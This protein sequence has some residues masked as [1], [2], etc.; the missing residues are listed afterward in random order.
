MSAEQLA[1][2]TQMFH[3]LNELNSRSQRFETSQAE[4]KTSIEEIKQSQKTIDAKI[5]SIGERLTS[6]E[7]K[8]LTLECEID[9]LRRENSDQKK[10]N[11]A[12]HTRL[13]EMEDQ[14]RRNN[15]LFYG[16][17]DDASETWSQAEEKIKNALSSCFDKGSAGPTANALSLDIERAHRLGKFFANQCR[18]VIVKFSSFKTKDQVMQLRARLKLNRIS[19]SEDFCRA[20]RL[21]RKNLIE[22]GKTQNST[23]KLSY[24]KLFVNDK[25]YI[26]DQELNRVLEL[27]RPRASPVAVQL[28]SNSEGASTS[29]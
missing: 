25:C 18:P 12:L 15:L 28:S 23:F 1:Q 17:P 29:F 11:A 19:V 14:S 16:I 7:N 21:A 5:T 22:F 2:F 27:P 13:N 10:V 9:A 3:L 24:N 6:V 4:L 20:T 8:S 26:Y